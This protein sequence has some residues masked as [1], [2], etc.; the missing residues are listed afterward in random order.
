[1]KKSIELIKQMPG[2]K[3]LEVSGN[4][5]VCVFEPEEE[6][7]PLFINSLG[8]EFFKED[9]AWW[10]CKEDYSLGHGDVC[11]GNCILPANYSEVYKTKETAYRKS[12]EYAHKQGE[13]IELLNDKKQFVHIQEPSWYW[14]NG[15][16]Y[17]IQQEPDWLGSLWNVDPRLAEAAAKDLG[18]KNRR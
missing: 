14:D 18:Y 17:R 3:T 9:D 6:K 11:Y 8:E 4:V 15:Y 16:H 12:V 2:L 13:R 1:M 7:K 5:A 10:F